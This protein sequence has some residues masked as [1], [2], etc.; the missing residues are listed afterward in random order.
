MEWTFEE[1]K[2][3]ENAIAEFDHNSSDIF[4]KIASRVPGK[5]IDQIMEHCKALVDDVDMIE[6]GLVPLPDYKDA[7][8]N[9]VI[10]WRN[11]SGHRS[12]RKAIPW[13]KEEHEFVSSTSTCVCFYYA[14]LYLS[15]LKVPTRLIVIYSL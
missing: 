11:N 2:L 8:N 1:N 5:T 10:K 6:Q 15:P 9:D 14:S 3:F 7:I 4:R 12:R 13:T